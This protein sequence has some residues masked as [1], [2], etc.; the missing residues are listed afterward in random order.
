MADD[1]IEVFRSSGGRGIA[2]IIREEEVVEVVEVE[3]EE[4]DE[5]E[6]LFWWKIGCGRRGRGD[7]SSGKAASM[8]KLSGREKPLDRELQWAE[9]KGDFF[10]K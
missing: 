5:I 1:D 2:G 6:G 4:E 10:W 7:S 3:G 9:A 8:P